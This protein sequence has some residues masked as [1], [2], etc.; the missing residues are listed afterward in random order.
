MA[1]YDPFPYSNWKKEVERKGYNFTRKKNEKKM[2]SEKNW[3]KI[4][5]KKEEILK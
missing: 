3:K 5:L 4:I 2:R 1:P